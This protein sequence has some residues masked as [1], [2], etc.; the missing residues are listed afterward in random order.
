MSRLHW[1]SKRDNNLDQSES[2][3][4]FSSTITTTSTP[5]RVEDEELDSSD[6]VSEEELLDGVITPSA[7]LQED[8]H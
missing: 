6:S 4:D 1:R 5:A 8:Y 2:Q 7:Q 3:D